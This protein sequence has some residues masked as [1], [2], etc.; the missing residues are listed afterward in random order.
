MNDIAQYNNYCIQFVSFILLMMAVCVWKKASKKLYTVH[1]KVLGYKEICPRTSTLSEEE[2]LL[3]FGRD[4]GSS[5][6][7]LV[8]LLAVPAESRHWQR[9]VVIWENPAVCRWQKCRCEGRRFLS[10]L[11]VDSHKHHI[12]TTFCF[13]VRLNSPICSI[14]TSFWFVSK[15]FNRICTCDLCNTSAMYYHNT[16]YLTIVSI[17]KE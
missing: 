14:R 5:L 17:H 13:I 4:L 7:K 2:P 9:T 12:F 1:I 6:T 8:L 10:G 3:D 15:S 16:Q 11:T